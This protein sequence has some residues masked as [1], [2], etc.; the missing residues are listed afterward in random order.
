M[1]YID[2]RDACSG[3]GGESGGEGARVVSDFE[4]LVKLLDGDSDCLRVDT[5]RC[6]LGS[7][8]SYVM[9]WEKC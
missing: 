7:D 3:A 2:T 6:R 8:I 5:E 1:D 9:T 4:A